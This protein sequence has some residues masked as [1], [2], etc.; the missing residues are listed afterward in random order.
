MTTNT[1]STE[2][3]HTLPNKAFDLEYS[4][5]Y[6]KEMLYLKDHGFR[7]T[8]VKKTLDYH[9]PTYKYTKTPELFRCIADFYEQ[10]RLEKKFNGLNDV[11]DAARILD[12]NHEEDEGMIFDE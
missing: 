2:T 10:Q 11:V 6:K 8:F 1:I 5:Q 3:N 4:T 7:Y 9:V 12:M